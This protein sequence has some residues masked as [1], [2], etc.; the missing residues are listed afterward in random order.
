VLNSFTVEY[1]EN[2]ELEFN[3]KSISARLSSFRA[4][5]ALHRTV[6]RAKRDPESRVFKQFWIPA[7]AGMT[8]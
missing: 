8:E 6:F 3:H 1:A 7:F 5:E 4:S 2:A